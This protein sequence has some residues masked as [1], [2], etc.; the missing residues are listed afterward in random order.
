MLEPSREDGDPRHALRERGLMEIVGD[1]FSIYG[2]RLVPIVLISAV[3]QIPTAIPAFI[4]LQSTGF[5]AVLAF[6]NGAALTLVYA[7]IVAAVAQNCAFGRVS[8]SACFM[9]VAWRGVSVLAIAALFGALSAIAAVAAEPLALWGEETAALAQEAAETREAASETVAVLGADQAAETPEAVEVP[10]LPGASALTL[11]VAAALFL[12]LA[13]YMTTVAPSVIIEGRRGFGAAARG[14]QLARGSEWR[15]F[16]HILIYGLTTGGITVAIVLP[17]LIAGGGPQAGASPLP[18]IGGAAAQIIAQPVIYIA[19]TL[20]YFDIRLKNE[21]GYGAARLSEE[22]GA[23][24]L[25]RS[26]SE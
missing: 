10:P 1:T 5:S 11:T 24:R 25:R 15:I 21:E 18:V 8:P 7:A 19:A 23:A 9:R 4:P 26:Q 16:G 14:F 17:F 6:I 13:V 3:V 12:I 20:L 22:M 2:A